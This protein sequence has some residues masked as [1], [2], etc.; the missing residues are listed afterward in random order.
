MNTIATQLDCMHYLCC[1]YWLIFAVTNCCSKSGWAKISQKGP[2]SGCS[3]EMT[4][5]VNLSV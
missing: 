5:N 4:I 3:C 1:V 2:N